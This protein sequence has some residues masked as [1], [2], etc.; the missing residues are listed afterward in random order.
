MRY[1]VILCF[2]RHLTLNSVQV[3]TGVETA[4][5]YFLDRL[6]MTTISLRMLINQHLYVH[7]ANIAAPRH[8]GRINPHC[9]VVAEIRRAYSEAARLCDVHYGKHPELKLVSNNRGQIYKNRLY[10]NQINLFQSYFAH[11]G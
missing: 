2:P 11:N 8:V 7:G 10:Q 9:D 4:V 3:D 6:Y 5:Q 1:F